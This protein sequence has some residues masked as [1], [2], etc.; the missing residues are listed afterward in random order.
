VYI[1]NYFTTQTCPSKSYILNGLP[2]RVSGRILLYGLTV[3]TQMLSRVRRTA[4][5]HRAAPVRIGRQFGI[6]YA[7]KSDSGFHGNK[8]E[9]PDRRFKY[10]STLADEFNRSLGTIFLHDSW[11]A[12][13]GLFPSGRLFG[14]KEHFIRNHMSREDTE[15]NLDNSPRLSTSA[16]PCQ[17]M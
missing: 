15:I 10:G 14:Q 6:S 1:I 5:R 3:S 17:A 16:S 13:R 2:P 4:K 7:S 11:G 8:R 9:L 12:R